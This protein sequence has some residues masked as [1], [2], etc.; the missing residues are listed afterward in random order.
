M[1][2]AVSFSHQATEA[3]NYKNLAV[4]T[5]RF[6]PYTISSLVLYLYSMVRLSEKGVY[7]R[8][9]GSLS[10][11][12]TMPN[13]CYNRGYTCRHTRRYERLYNSAPGFIFTRYLQRY[14]KQR[15]RKQFMLCLFVRCNVEILAPSPVIHP[16]IL[17]YLPVP[18]DSPTPQV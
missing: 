9:A 7:V 17:G 8:T 2:P 1:S 10:P 3:R 11:P 12:H 4:R 15:K 16:S 13:F 14:Q 6:F 5:G 18:C